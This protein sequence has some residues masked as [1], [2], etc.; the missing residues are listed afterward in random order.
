MEQWL[1][2]A[3]TAPALYSVNVYIDKYLLESKVKN[4]RGLP[5]YTS[6]AGFLSGT[7]AWI[8][9]GFPTLNWFEGGV[10]ML[11]GVLSAF[12]LTFYFEALS[13]EES[14]SVII[15]FQMIPVIT[16]LLA[17]FLLGETILPQ[18]VVGF[19]LVIVASLGATLKFKKNE[20]FFSP[21]WGLIFT[22]G[23]LWAVGN[24]LF[25]FVSSETGFFNLLAY[26]GWGFGLGGLSLFIF[27]SSIRNAFLENYRYVGKTVTVTIFTNEAIF[28]IARL[29]SYYAITLASSA[30]LVSVI[31]STQVFFGV[32]YGLI[33]AS[34]APHIF[35]ENITRSAL[36][37]KI[38]WGGLAVVGIYLI[39]I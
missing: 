1:W 29:C 13:Q 23:L 39:S 28:V 19:T 35:K 34:V 33:L 30:A 21:V 8:L 38:I 24:I 20:K 5:I 14:S 26:T 25:R 32:L 22:Y 2:L 11:S 3:F 37:K 6:L 17:Y 36:I 7:L 12:A 4:Y 15:L 27:S 16:L 18:Q 9:L 10:V 31:S